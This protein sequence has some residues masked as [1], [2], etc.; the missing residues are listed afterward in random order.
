M[1][2]SFDPFTY[3]GDGSDPEEVPFETIPP[4]DTPAL[5]GEIIEPEPAAEKIEP[6][7]APG[8][9]TLSGRFEARSYTAAEVI[10]Q[11]P[12]RTCRVQLRHDR[13]SIFA[14]KAEITRW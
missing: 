6:D 4:R 3:E 13:H 5:D 12:G 14:I 11:T 9:F 10:E 7:A 2:K 1:A 8:S